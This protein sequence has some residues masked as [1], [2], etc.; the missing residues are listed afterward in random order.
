MKPGIRQA[1]IPGIF[2]WTAPAKS[3]ILLISSPDEFDAWFEAN[4]KDGRNIY[5]SSL[6]GVG[7]S[8]YDDWTLPLNA[9]YRFPEVQAYFKSSFLLPSPAAKDDEG[10]YAFNRTG[11]AAI[12]S[13]LNKGR[14]VSIGI[15]ADQSAPGSK[16]GESG[17][18]NTATW[19]QYYSG[20]SRMNHL[21]TIVGYDDNYPKENFTHQLKNGSTDGRKLIETV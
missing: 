3:G 12:K 18:M 13:E 15:Q 6:S 5:G 1:R 17:Y 8:P 9:Q 10:N 19:S 14:G 20:E 16:P 11:V 7:Y 4:W 2:I 21:V